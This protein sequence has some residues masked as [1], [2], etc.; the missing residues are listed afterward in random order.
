MMQCLSGRTGGAS[1]REP[2]TNLLQ[3]ENSSLRNQM[4]MMKREMEDL[5][6]GLVEV[7]SRTIIRTVEP[8]CDLW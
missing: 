3:Q 1:A 8:L 7:R 6:S 4:S 5:Q 2:P